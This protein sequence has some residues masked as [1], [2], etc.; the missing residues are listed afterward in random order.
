M[1]SISNQLLLEA[2]KHYGIT[3]IPGRRHN[4]R[5]VRYLAAVGLR[6]RDETPW[7]SAFANYVAQQ[8]GAE[9]TGKGL[10][11]SW[12][13]IGEEVLLEEAEPGDVVVF[14]RG[15]SSWSGHVAF[16]V[17]YTRSRIWVLGGNQSN[18]VRVSPYRRRDLI[19]V[20]RLSATKK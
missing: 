2:L 7:C 1:N 16:F 13:K 17:R 12:A 18:Q 11:R 19:T 6:G 9:R 4:P 15:R 5:I 8:V 20:R 3:E 10:A 14:R